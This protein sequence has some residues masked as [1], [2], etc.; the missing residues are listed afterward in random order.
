MRGQRTG[1]RTD[2]AFDQRERTAQLSQHRGVDQVL[3]GRPQWT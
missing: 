3:A 2:I 1:E